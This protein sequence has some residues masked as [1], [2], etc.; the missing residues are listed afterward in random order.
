[1]QFINDPHGIMC[2]IPPGICLGYIK[3]EYMRLEPETYY[4]A[5]TGL[6]ISQEEMLSIYNKMKELNENR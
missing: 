5:T 3:K 4:F 2:M 6:V 1:M